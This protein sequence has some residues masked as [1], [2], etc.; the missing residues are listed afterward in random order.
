MTE[1]TK[2]PAQRDP[3]IR[4]GGIRDRALRA[5]GHRDQVT[6]VSALGGAQRGARCRRCNA[7]IHPNAPECWHCG[8]PCR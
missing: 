2:E 1:R 3:G 4:P 8:H 6:F 7:R 5:I